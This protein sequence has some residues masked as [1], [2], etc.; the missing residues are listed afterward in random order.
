[1]KGFLLLVELAA[2]LLPL[3]LSPTSGP[4]MIRH[5]LVSVANGNYCAVIC[6]LPY[7]VICLFR[8]LLCFN[9]LQ[10]APSHSVTSAIKSQTSTLAQKGHV[11]IGLQ[12]VYSREEC[13][14]KKR[15]FKCTCT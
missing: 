12:C 5:L 7:C 14:C 13:H 1:M 9:H 8:I 6:S 15:S 11:F 2:S 4:K 10:F 3:P